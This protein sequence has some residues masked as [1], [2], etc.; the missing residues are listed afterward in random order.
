MTTVI[1]NT[2]CRQESICDRF[3]YS[4]ARAASYRPRLESIPSKAADFAGPTGDL[5]P[6]AVCDLLI[7]SFVVGVHPVQPLFDLTAFRKSY[8]E[9][10]RLLAAPEVS[11]DMVA[12]DPKLTA[13]RLAVLFCGAVAAPATFWASAPALAC[14]EAEAT[15]ELLRRSYIQALDHCEWTRQPCTE[16]LVAALLTHGCCKGSGGGSDDLAF[17]QAAVRMAQS[18]GLHRK[19]AGGPLALSQ[20]QARHRIWWHIV[21]LDAQYSLRYGASTCCGVEGTH[22]D[23][24]MPTVE[25][26]EDTGLLLDEVSTEAVDADPSAAV[27]K[28]YTRGRFEAVRLTHALLNQVNTCDPLRQADLPR[29]RA[30]FEQLHDRLKR[31]CATMPTTGVPEQGFVPLRLANA[32][33]STHE[34]LYMGGKRH[35]GGCSPSVLVSWVRIALSTLATASLLGLHKLFLEHPGMTVQQNQALWEHC[36]QLALDVLRNLVHTVR[37][38]AFAPYAWFLPCEIMFCQA[39]LV[40][41]V[42]LRKDDNG[43]SAE[44]AQL[45]RH[46]VDEALEGVNYFSRYNAQ[47]LNIISLQTLK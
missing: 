11:S 17:V 36:F 27:S 34:E 44:T 46:L 10:W 3:I 31:L 42:F 24:P 37:V 43:L 13:L 47:I 28:L 39:I 41:L 9:F 5:P 20:R 7:Y 22:W 1:I 33:M 8:D 38:P 2:T 26:V 4:T 32:A 15:V 18:M 6:K 40:V 16:T 14:L 35:P 45:A 23:V 30:D 12:K 29:H 25:G 19:G 21:D